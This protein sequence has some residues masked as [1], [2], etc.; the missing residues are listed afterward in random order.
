MLIID[1]LILKIWATYFFSSLLGILAAVVVLDVAD[2]LANK[3]DII[4]ALKIGSQLLPPT[5]EVLAPFC[6][7][8]ATVFT[9]IALYRHNEILVIKQM[10]FS[11]LRIMR[12]VIIFGSLIGLFL[13]INQS[14]LVRWLNA[15]ERGYGLTTAEEELSWYYFDDQL[16]KI[17]NPRILFGSIDSAEILS[18]DFDDWSTEKLSLTELSYN[19]QWMA[20]R[21]EVFAYKSGQLSHLEY[22]NYLVDSAIDLTSLANSPI[23]PHV[24]LPLEQLYASW[25]KSHLGDYATDLSL[26]LIMRKLSYILGGLILIILGSLLADFRPRESR[27]IA[28]VVVITLIY[29]FYWFL[30]NLFFLMAKEGTIPLI[31][32]G[33]GANILL[34]SG[35]MIFLK[36]SRA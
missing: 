3:P 10:G 28:T 18:F 29:Y 4:R 19:G 7:L 12:S 2:T 32:G 8:L 27:V 21:A 14:Y 17:K 34:L 1:R 31:W 13:Y 26:L 33:L 25:Q 5:I 35:L 20:A 23:Y 36:K 30:D 11:Q 9:F 6:V 24:Y 22:D 16:V 15:E